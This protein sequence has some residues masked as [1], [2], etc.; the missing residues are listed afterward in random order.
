MMPSP[1]EVGMILK[2]LGLSILTL[3][4]A[5]CNVVGDDSST[6]AVMERVKRDWM[7]E[8]LLVESEVIARDIWGSR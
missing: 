3:A 2:I 8:Q 5:A 1:M 6:D 7:A 4:L